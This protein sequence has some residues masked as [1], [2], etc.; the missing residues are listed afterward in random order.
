MRSLHTS[1]IQSSE[2]TDYDQSDE[3][4]DDDESTDDE[5]TDDDEETPSEI[6]Y[7]CSVAFR[8]RKVKFLSSSPTATAV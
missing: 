3:S 6:P 7:F 8:F 1:Q 2:S 5:S 4:S